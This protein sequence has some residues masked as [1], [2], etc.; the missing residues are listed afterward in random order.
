VAENSTMKILWHTLAVGSKSIQ[1]SNSNPRN[2]R[3]PSFP[4][5]NHLHIHRGLDGSRATNR[6]SIFEIP[7][8]LEYVSRESDYKKCSQKQ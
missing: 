6:I 3:C 4:S 7:F 5:V 2:L 8:K 1:T